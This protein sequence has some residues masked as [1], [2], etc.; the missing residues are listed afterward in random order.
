MAITPESD[1]LYNAV[2]IEG[3]EFHDGFLSFSRL[4]V[5]KIL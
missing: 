3:S 1:R 4:I 2:A 5:Y